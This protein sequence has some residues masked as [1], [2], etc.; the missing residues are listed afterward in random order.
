MW[1]NACVHPVNNWLVR[2]RDIDMTLKPLANKQQ[3]KSVFNTTK[4]RLEVGAIA[5]IVSKPKPA[6]G[7]HGRHVFRV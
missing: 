1:C 5:S 7:S 3:T 4:A 2:W 6:C